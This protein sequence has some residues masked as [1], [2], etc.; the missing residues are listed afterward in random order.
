MAMHKLMVPEPPVFTGDSINFIEFKQ[1][2]VALV[3]K[4]SVSSAD[5]M[6]YLKKYVRGLATNALEGTFF[7]TDDEAYQDAWCRLNNRYDQPF[8]M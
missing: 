4:K 5:N 2:F 3:D 6:F 8:V 1:S 7:R